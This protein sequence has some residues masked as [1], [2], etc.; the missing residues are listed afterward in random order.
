M[1]PLVAVQAALMPYLIGAVSALGGRVLDFIPER[2]V[3]P[4]ARVSTPSRVPIAETCKFRTALMVQIDFW[5]DAPESREV[6]EIAG[7]ALTAL[8]EQESSLTVTGFVVDS[9]MVEGIFY[10]REQETLLQRG[11]LMLAIDVQP[12]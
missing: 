1:D 3:Y 5:S 6:K 10:S 11:R 9:M 4:Y 8:H 2:P 7:A 12:A